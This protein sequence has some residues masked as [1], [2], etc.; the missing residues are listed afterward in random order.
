MTVI[1]RLIPLCVPQMPFQKFA[2]VYLHLD[3]RI[4][5]DYKSNLK[6][7]AYFRYVKNANK[8]NTTKIMQSNLFLV[9]EGAPDWI[10]AESLF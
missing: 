10:S 1:S 3:G 7:M 9:T 5:H 2:L 6:N 8:E 4:T